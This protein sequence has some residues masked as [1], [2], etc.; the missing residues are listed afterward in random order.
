MNTYYVPGTRVNDKTGQRM[1]FLQGQDKDFAKSF[2]FDRCCH[3]AVH[4]W[5]RRSQ[6]CLLPPHI[7]LRTNRGESSFSDAQEAAPAPF[8]PHP[9]PAD[10]NTL[11]AVTGCAVWEA[12]N[13]RP[14]WEA[15][16]KNTGSGSRGVQG[17]RPQIR[18][19]FTQSGTEAEEQELAV[20]TWGLSIEG[21][22]ELSL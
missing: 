17:Q 20:G 7:I 21:P 3:S 14:L 19:R 1:S 8:C 4:L 15:H 5:C 18:P 13:P 9:Y 22:V 11:A 16:V 2:H 10:L 6:D 12:R